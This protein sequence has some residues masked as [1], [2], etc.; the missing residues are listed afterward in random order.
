M[1]CH[2]F[3]LIGHQKVCTFACGQQQHCK[4]DATSQDMHNSASCLAYGLTMDCT[5]HHSQASPVQT[6]LW[7]ATLQC[8]TCCGRQQQP[9]CP[10]EQPGLGAERQSGQPAVALPLLVHA[11]VSG[12]RLCCSLP[13]L[14]FTPASGCCGQSH[15]S[16][17]CSHG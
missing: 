9:P 13:L 17:C 10:A 5:V 15:D 14:H 2:V 1:L 4:P 6:M 3:A 7:S 16:R 12:W 11:A 8:S